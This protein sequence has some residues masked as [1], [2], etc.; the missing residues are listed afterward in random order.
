[1][2]GESLGD[3]L[4]DR[5]DDVR[6]RLLARLDAAIA[7]AR[8]VKGPLGDAAAARR[9]LAE[10]IDAVQ[11]VLAAEVVSVLGVTVGFSDNDGDSG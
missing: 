2:E 6:G 7:I 8:A 5:S 4:G 9:R 10:A 11:T 3:L 1:M